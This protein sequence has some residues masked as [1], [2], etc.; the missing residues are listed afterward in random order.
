MPPHREKHVQWLKSNVVDEASLA[1]SSWRGK[2][3]EKHLSSLAVTP[4]HKVQPL[5][6]SLNG[7]NH[8]SS[9]MEV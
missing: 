3:L 9:K 4:S 8:P 1:D 5:D 7:K 2:G 6:H